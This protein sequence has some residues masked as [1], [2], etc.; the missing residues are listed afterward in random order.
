MSELMGLDV[1]EKRIGVA[2]ADKSVRI[3]IPYGWIQ[4]DGTEVAEINNLII[5]EGVKNLVV[6]LPRNSSGEETKQSEVVREF[7]RNF[8]LSGV[9]I[10]WQDESLTS[11][12]AEERLKSYG[13]P[14]D[15]GEVDSQA[16]A[17][18]LQDFLEGN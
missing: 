11:V 5:G 12:K 2:F 8:D 15:K 1:G 14:Y 7:M 6:G 4:V 9:K 3:A 16:A 10:H 17:I 18:I 13:K